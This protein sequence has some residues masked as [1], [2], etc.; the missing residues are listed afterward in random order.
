MIRRDA[1]LLETSMPSLASNH[2]STKTLRTIPF[3][4]CFG[5]DVRAAGFRG[6]VF[7]GLPD[8][9]Q[10]SYLKGSAAAQT[11]QVMENLKAV[12]F[13]AGTEFERVVKTTIYLEDMADMSGATLQMK[14]DAR[15]RMGA[16]LKTEWG[17]AFEDRYAVVEKHL[18]EL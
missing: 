8:D 12:L 6:P 4:G 18:S 17:M 1:E 3:A 16:E 5:A 11:K 14:E 7:V 2:E 15:V 13:A 9:S 10:S